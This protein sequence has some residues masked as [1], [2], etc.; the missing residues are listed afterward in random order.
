M[1]N[2]KQPNGCQTEQTYVELKSRMKMRL[3]S[4]IQSGK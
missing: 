4:T 3:A 2:M 1:R